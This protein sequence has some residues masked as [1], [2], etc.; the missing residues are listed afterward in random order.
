[1]EHVEVLKL[2]LCLELH[3]FCSVFLKGN[4]EHEGT[5]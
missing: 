2:G 4:K 3:W 1:M 5:E